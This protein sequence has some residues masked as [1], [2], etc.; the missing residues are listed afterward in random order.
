MDDTPICPCCGARMQV[1]RQKRNPTAEFLGC[2][3]YPACT[4]TLPITGNPEEEQEPESPYSFD[5]R[6]SRRYDN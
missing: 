1:R 4:G 3:R 2:S 5:Q 6:K